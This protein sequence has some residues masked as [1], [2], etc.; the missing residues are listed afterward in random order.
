MNIQYIFHK[1]NVNYIL[2]GV[3]KFKLCHN[4]L[5]CALN[6]WPPFKLDACWLQADV[7]L[8]S[9]IHFC[10][11]SQYVCLHVCAVQVITFAL[12]VVSK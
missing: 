11:G 4:L 1:Y 9:L 3:A 10:P 12:T 5:S 7:Q 8:I 2:C 6:I